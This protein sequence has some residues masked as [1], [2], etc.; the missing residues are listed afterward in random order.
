MRRR[1]KKAGCGSGLAGLS[2]TKDYFC[3]PEESESESER[4]RLIPRV[5][6]GC[7]LN[8]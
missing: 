1:R 4:A 5:Y 3:R 6:S 8:G 7:V 2:K